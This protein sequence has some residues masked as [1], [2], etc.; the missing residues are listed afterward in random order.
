MRTLSGRIGLTLLV[1]ALV[2]LLALGGTLWFALRELHRDATTASLTELTVPWAAALRS[3][4]P[5]SSTSW[6]GEA[7]G[8]RW[9]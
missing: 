7:H 3:Q 6:A 1:F 4:F 9:S 2:T 8:L 5:G